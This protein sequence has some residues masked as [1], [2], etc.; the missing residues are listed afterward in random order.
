MQLLPNLIFLIVGIAILFE[1]YQFLDLETLLIE[2]EKP[3]KRSL[4]SFWVIIFLINLSL[5][6]L[7]GVAIS[8]SGK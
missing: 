7:L 3:E 6:T 4:Y 8:I 2:L 1:I 5:F